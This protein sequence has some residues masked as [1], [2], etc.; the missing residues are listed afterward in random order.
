MLLK[1]LTAWRFIGSFLNLLAPFA[2]ALLSIAACGAKASEPGLVGHWKLQGD[3]LDSSGHENHG[4][5]HGVNLDRGEFDGQHAYIEVPAS[6]S[7]QVGNRDFSFCA[8]INTPAELD[9][10]VGDVFDLYDPAR[11]RGIT[12]TINSSAGG[13]QAQGT[14]RHVHFGIDDGRVTEWQDCGHPNPASNYVYN[15]LTVYKGKLY[16]ATS[17]GKDEQDWRHVYRYEGGQKWIDCGQVGSSRAEGV[18]PLIV[19]QGDLY[20]VTTTIDWTRVQT[21]KYDPA[22]VY[23]YLGGDHWEDCGQPSANPTLNCIAS[24]RGKLY[25]GGGSENFGVFEYQ[26]GVE[27]RPSKLFSNREVPNGCF[28]HCMCRHSGKLFVGYPGA[29]AFDGKAWTFAGLPSDKDWFLQTHSMTIFRG[30]LQA[31]TWP[32]SKVASYEG[33]EAWKVLGRVGV[34]GTEVNSLAVYNG[35]LYGGALPFAEACRYDDQFDW[36]SLNRFYSPPSFKPGPPGK[37]SREDVKEASRLTSL[38]VYNGRLF[39]SVGS[40]TSSILDAPADVRGKVFSME[41]GKVASY[42][43]D[44]GPGWKHIAAVR[45]NDRLKLY[46]NGKLKAESSP[47][48]PAQYD[49]KTDRPLRIG[50]GETEYFVG[51]MA[52]VRFYNVTLDEQRIAALGA[53]KPE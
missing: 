15:S 40:S 33:G 5:N 7:L 35:K 6:A 28:P 37:M 31:G 11:R 32:E 29:H 46:I 38:T 4:V 2:I 18:G 14:D 53:E 19:H 36:I 39:A 50:F 10:I 16:A 34:E 25:V 52:D 45:S 30:K 42:D 26:G 27:W 17:G 3:C 51:K 47:F 21:G 43:D 49:L 44:L 24:Y 9:D 22:R 48:D 23:R 20:A 13:Y 41:A 1:K 8:W 12:L